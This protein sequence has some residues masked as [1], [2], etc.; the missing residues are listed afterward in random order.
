MLTPT[1]FTLQFTTSNGGVSNAY[2]RAPYA[3]TVRDLLVTCQADP[4]DADV[5]S[6]LDSSAHSIGTC[7]FGSGL[8]AG[9]AAGAFAPDATYGNTQF[10]DGDL[11]QLQ[12]TQCDAAVVL[13]CVLTLDPFCLTV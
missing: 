11:I 9:A 10:A 4:G 13:L 1:T 2:F 12:C 5:V 8:A 6:V 7:T 3:C